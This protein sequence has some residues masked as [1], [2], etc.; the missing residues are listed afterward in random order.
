MKC[1]KPWSFVLGI[2]LTLIIVPK[3]SL[4]GDNLL[5]TDSSFVQFYPQF[6]K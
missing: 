5:I 3:L 4:A 2:L 6:M 1:E